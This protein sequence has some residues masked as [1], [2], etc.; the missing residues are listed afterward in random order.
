[1]RIFLSYNGAPRYCESLLHSAPF[2]SIMGYKLNS[3]K[4]K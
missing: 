1:M 2:R 4:G 3:G